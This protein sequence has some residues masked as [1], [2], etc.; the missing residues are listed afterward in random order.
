M[1]GTGHPSNPPGRREHVLAGGAPSGSLHSGGRA[2]RR[3]KPNMSRKRGRKRGR[4]FYAFSQTPLGKR[5]SP[6]GEQLH[7]NASMQY[8]RGH[9]NT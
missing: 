6:D 3:Q 5:G 2:G 9:E 7:T 4:R 1:A 8:Y